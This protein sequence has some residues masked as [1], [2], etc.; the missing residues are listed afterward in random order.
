MAKIQ[1]KL[2]PLTNNATMV[3]KDW[4]VH[5]L[6]DIKV[7]DKVERFH[8]YR[9]S[10]HNGKL[11]Y[12][13]RYTDEEIYGKWF[14]VFGCSTRWIN[15]IGSNREAPVVIAALHEELERI[16]DNLPGK[17]GYDDVKVG[18]PVAREEDFTTI[19]SCLKYTPLKDGTHTSRRA[20]L[21]AEANFED[22]MARAQALSELLES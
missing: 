11:M 12:G 5:A 19:N 2:V 6:V 17:V 1:Y 13:K 15:K 10:G 18:I 9:S 21:I 20:C 7:K 22:C 16:Y 3:K 14:M 4:R 8:F